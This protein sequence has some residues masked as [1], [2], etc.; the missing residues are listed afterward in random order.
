MIRR[1][2]WPFAA[3][4]VLVAAVACDKQ[5][6]GPTV[7]PENT[8]AVRVTVQRDTSRSGVPAPFAAGSGVRVS[9]FRLGDTLALRQVTANSAGQAVFVGLAPGQYVV[10]PSLRPLST[11]IGNTAD[12]ITVTANDTTTIASD[13]IR[14]RLGA[15]ITGFL[16]AEITGQQGL[17]RTRF[18]GVQIAVLR[19]TGAGTGIY[20]PFTT[21]T[22]DATGSFDVPLVPGPGRVQL[23]FNSNGIPGFPNDTLFFGGTGTTVLTV[24][25]THV[26]SNLS[27]SGGTGVAPDATIT[28]NL[29]F[30]FNTRITGAVFRD[31]NMNG[32][33]DAGEPG[34]IAGDTVTVQLRDATGQRVLA[35]QRLIGPS[36][37]PQ[38]YTFSGLAGGTYVIALDPASKFAAPAA[39][40]QFSPVTVTL[41][42]SLAA[43]AGT[44]PAAQAVVVNIPITP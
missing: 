36:L 18:P 33:L 8:G 43:V 41:P 24:R 44:P 15:R 27:S 14:V 34:L 17:V 32:T 30:S 12:T 1:S 39:A 23:V 28:R 21:V 40:A 10:R 31:T 19:E 26:V 5:P 6:A 22:T 7:R 38:T 29:I 37:T 20:V 11:S 16:A 9:L 3:G 4:V 13:T 25:P 35:S 42:T 2:L